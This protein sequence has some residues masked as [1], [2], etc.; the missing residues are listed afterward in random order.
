M[1]DKDDELLQAYL[2]Y[3]KRDYAA[4]LREMESDTV[5]VHFTHNE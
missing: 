5:N 1:L 4:C 2:Y 3:K